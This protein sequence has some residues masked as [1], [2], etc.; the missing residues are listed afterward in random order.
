ML[1]PS[2]MVAK[3]GTIVWRHSDGGCDGDDNEDGCDADDSDDDCEC[4]E[5]VITGLQIM[6]MMIVTV[7]TMMMIVRSW[8]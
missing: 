6:M 1:H 3:F 2:K 8:Q 7:A 4:V 5:M